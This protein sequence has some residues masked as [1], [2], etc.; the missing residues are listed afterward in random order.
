[1]AA[2]SYDE[3]FKKFPAHKLEKL[4]DIFPNCLPRMIN[5]DWLCLITNSDQFSLYQHS[6]LDRC[7]TLQT[8]AP[9][10]WRDC[11]SPIYLALIQKYC[12][13]E[14]QPTAILERYITLFPSHFDKSILPTV[15]TKLS[16]LSPEIQAYLLGFPIHQIL[17][18]PSMLNSAKEKLERLGLEQY[19]NDIEDANRRSLLEFKTLQEGEINIGNT[20]N[21]LGD[22]DCQYNLFDV[23]VY[24]IDNIRYFF[25]RVEFESTLDK[26]VNH[27]TNVPLP[28]ILK[29]QIKARHHLAK[30]L[31]LPK[32]APLRI[33]FQ[34]LLDDKLSFESRPKQSSSRSAELLLGVFLNLLHND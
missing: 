25:T 29:S 27:W 18:T 15:A 20:E 34:E 26:G 6:I 28:P 9:I 17:P 11:M 4:N 30:K 14:I 24:V 19:F 3:H 8:S 1:M 2:R 12:I 22:E 10:Y 32:S 7:S 5:H 33:L 31:K 21:T 13:L 23:I 16:R